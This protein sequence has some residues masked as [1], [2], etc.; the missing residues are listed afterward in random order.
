LFNH[1]FSGFLLLSSIANSPLSK[2]SL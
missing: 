1:L 2:I